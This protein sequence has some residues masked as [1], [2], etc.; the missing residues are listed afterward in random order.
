MSPGMCRTRYTFWEKLITNKWCT[1]F[2]KI[3]NQTS[4][5][6]YSVLFLLDWLTSKAGEA[7]LPF[8]LTHYLRVKILI[9]SCFPKCVHPCLISNSVSLSAPVISISI[10]L[11]I[12]KANF[13]ETVRW[14]A[15]SRLIFP[16]MIMGS[17]LQNATHSQPCVILKCACLISD[18]SPQRSG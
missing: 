14:I 5:R 7:S 10:Y 2:H 9:H 16:T 4:S 13:G 6:L 3:S 15:L 8:C 1:E 11:H 18:A 12:Y 17:N